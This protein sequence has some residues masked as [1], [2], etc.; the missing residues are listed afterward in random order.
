MNRKHSREYYFELVSRIRASRSDIGLSSDFIV[1]FPGETDSDFAATLDLVREVGYAQAFSFKYSARP[2]T[3][4][5]AAGNQIPDQVK[6]DRLHALQELLSAQQDAF[7]ASCKGRIL[8][9]LF[10]KQGSK[11]GQAVGRS[12]WLQPVHVDNATHLIGTVRQVRI[13]DVL[14]NS[15]RGELISDK[16]PPLMVAH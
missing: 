12:P 13:A 1:G 3:P 5:A 8:P 14:P 7:N 9:V 4:A 15:L 11:T 16:V 6:S 10:E 2:G